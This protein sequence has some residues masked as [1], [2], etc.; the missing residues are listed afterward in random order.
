[1]LTAHANQN[2]QKARASDD[3]PLFA[4]ALYGFQESLTLWDANHRART[5]LT[6][7][8]RDYATAA[9]DNGDFDLAGSLLDTSN[10]EHQALMAKIDAA[11]AERD[12]RQRRLRLAK[13]AVAA[14]IAG[15]IITS[16]VAYF[17]VRQ[18]R[19]LA[20]VAEKE[21]R[22]AEKG[23]AAARQEAE[24]DRDAAQKA[25]EEE[26]I[27]RKE[28]EKAR[29]EAEQR[30][31]EAVIAQQNEAAAKKAEE[32]EAYI[33]QIGLA[34][35][36][37]NDNAYD[38]AKQLLAAKQSRAC[39]TGNGAGWPT[40][41]S[42]TRPRTTRPDRSTPSP[43]RPTASRS[44]AAT[45]P[46]SV[47]VRDAHSGAVRWEARHGQFVLAVA[48]S[49]DGSKIAS[50]S[51]DRKIQILDAASG[52]VLSTL[53]GHTDGVLS[54]RFSPDGTTT[55][56]R[57]VRQHGP[58]VGRGHRQHAA[59]A[60]RAQLVG[61]GRRV[62]AGCHEDR[63]RRPGRQ[64]D[65]VA[66]A[67]AD[68]SAE[69]EPMRAVS[70]RAPSHR[71]PQ[72]LYTYLTE[73]TGHNGAVYT[74]RFSPNGN[75][76]ATG[77]YDNLVMIWN[78]D[79]VQPVDIEQRLDGAPEPKANYLRLAGH[80]RPVR[81]VAFSPNGQLLAE[82]QRRQRDSRLGRRERQ[83]AEGASRPRQCGP[84][85][86]RS[87]RM[88]NGSSPAAR[89]RTFACG[90]CTVTRKLA[91]CTPRCSPATTMP[92]SPPA[93]R[94]TASRSSPPAAIARPAC[95]TRPPARS[96]NDSKKATSSWSPAR[97]SSATRQRALARAAGH[98]R[99]RQL[100]SHLGYD[101]RH[102]AS[103]SV[104]HRPHRHARRLAGRQMGGHRRARS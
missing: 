14:L 61:L 65:R 21:A 68:R 69:L 75:L 27:A 53:E 34:T 103:R 25:K 11:R 56:Q 9:L 6:E 23:E 18:E 102:P 49:P 52:N 54:V 30:R 66:E 12:A 57:L 38:F 20:L 97:R 41:A 77:G 98:R 73:F 76:V 24:K 43:I 42:S 86:S 72:P 5:L 93:S 82:R 100:G 70:D 80:D 59:R 45:W 15:I 91:C 92:C 58:P 84:L 90:T 60:Q 32:Y 4:R 94:A 3:Y 33:A 104:A 10:P 78:P 31:E 63:H 71:S 88:A 7:T 51:S 96:S 39:A 29:A 19:N 36:K 87:R 35:A 50:G 47:T 81:S 74:A 85:V 101:G 16:T 99:R 79:E 40:C 64:G 67:G 62:F 48:Y 1:M 83:A 37:I 17:V 2:L 44:P 95:G 89:I 28:E 22:E 46:A 8:Q 13:M 55:S 26:E